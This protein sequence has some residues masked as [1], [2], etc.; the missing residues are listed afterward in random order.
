MAIVLD[1]NLVVVLVSGDPRRPIAERLLRG[2]IDAGED[3][4]APELLPYEVA[5][6]LTRLVAAGVGARGVRESHP[7]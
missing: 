5:N 7:G 1:A 6:G 4:H 3:L 2:W